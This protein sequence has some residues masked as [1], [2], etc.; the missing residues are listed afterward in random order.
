MNST[1]TACTTGAKATERVG[2][3]RLAC[4]VRSCASCLRARRARIAARRRRRAGDRRRRRSSGPTRSRSATK[5]CCR[6]STPRARSPTSAG[7]SSGSASHGDSKAVLRFTAPAEVKGV[8]LLVVNHPDRA[9]DQWMW[10]PAIERD[11]RIALQDRSTRFFGTDF[12]FEDLEERDVDQYDYALLGDETDRRRGVL[13]DS[14]DAEADASRR[15][16][17]DRSCGSARTTTRSRGS[18]TTSRIRSSGGSNYSDIQNVQGIWT[19][20]QLEMADL[21][22]GSRTRLTLDKLEYNVPL[23]DDDFTLQAIRRQ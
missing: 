11:R 22:R 23:K 2:D 15:S 20:R 12:S 17:R 4:F 14:V 9:S 3:A 21:R 7:R 1:T 18:R 16:T 6:C 10:T 8:A 5:G 13:E 19:A